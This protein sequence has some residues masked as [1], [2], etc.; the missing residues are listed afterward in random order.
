MPDS[1]VRTK[2]RNAFGLAFV[3]AIGG[4]LFG[5][6]LGLIGAANV[7]L[8][9][10]FRLSDAEFGFATASAVL[11]CVAGPAFGFWLCDSISRR[12]TMLI[13]SLLLGVSAL[14]TAIPDVIGGGS[15]GS[16]LAV[17]NF[18]RFVG[19][20]GVGLCSV[21]SP[22][23][24]AEIAPAGKR[25]R[26]GLMY[27]LAI[28][29]G[30]A[31]AP[32]IAFCIIYFLRVKYGVTEAAIPEDPWLQAW[33]W[34]FLSEMLCILPFVA[35]VTR[36]PFS[37]RWLA[38]KGRFD[39]AREVL[40]SVD[41]PEYAAREI[42]EIRADVGKEKGTWS[43]LFAPGFRFAMFIAILLTFFNNWTGWSVI[44]GY[45]P[46]LLELAGFNRESAIGNFVA[47]YGAMGIMTL[48]SMALMDRVGRRPL[49]QFA[50]LLMAVIT[51][52]TGYMFYREIKGWPIL[53]ILGLVTIP[54]GIA[55]GGIP[56]LM[57]SEMFPT[58]I[59]AKAVSLATTVL[60]IFIFCGAY[61]FPMI[62]GFSQRHFLTARH[63]VVYGDTISFVASNPP[64]IDDSQ[65]RLVDAG[66][67]AG[68]QV[69]VMGAASPQNDGNFVVSDVTPGSLTLKSNARLIDEV[70]GTNVTLQ[71]GSAGAAF[72]L[73]SIIC[74]LSFLFGITIMPET[75]NRTL[76]DIGV[77]WQTE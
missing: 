49:W 20:L 11:G 63:T 33:R 8:R 37:P 5:F 15:R 30:H 1:L 19:G 75:K 4:L 67:Q 73:F 14:F 72:W 2:T 9:D 16:T 29:L 35:F 28:V 70:S 68:D 13:S 77:S 74:I 71:V 48:L 39:E 61:L 59:R 42:E 22:M 6:D 50:S 23:Y 66:F 62:T 64:R 10:Q 54:H 60:W 21:A 27:Q 65:N 57:M 52:A 40:T 53:L 3:A 46:R 55:L 47:V 38:E 45:I 32:L 24:I 58:R 34:M 7:Y 51:F 76:E 41:G 26:L 18:F 17:F 44:G 12:R 25:G 43:E 36:L 69:T 31:V 56:W